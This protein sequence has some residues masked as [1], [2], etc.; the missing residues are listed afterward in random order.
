[1]KV[2]VAVLRG[3]GTFL[4]Y[5]VMLI[6]HIL[7]LL[8][9]SLLA[10]MGLG[11]VW[12][13]LYDASPS[14]H[15]LEFYVAGAISLVI[16]LFLLGAFVCMIEVVKRKEKLWEQAALSHEIGG[17][18]TSPWRA[19]SLGWCLLTSACASLAASTGISAAVD[20]TWTT[21]YW[22]TL[23]VLLSI[24]QPLH[25]TA[26]LLIFRLL[27]STDGCCGRPM[28]MQ[29]VLHPDEIGNRNNI[30]YNY[31]CTRCGKSKEPA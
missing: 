23:W 14:E 15:T 22:K 5:A 8:M 19:A 7:L 24:G 9:F 26:T 29:A 17:V 3:V 28:E 20:H 13:Y 2:L 6:E 25:A 10:A 18:K 21:E 31:R 11:V 1:M 4:W 30:E 27:F 12:L 16:S